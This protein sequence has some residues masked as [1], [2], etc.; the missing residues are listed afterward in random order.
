MKQERMKP[1]KLKAKQ[2]AQTTT[3]QVNKFSAKVCF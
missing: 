3:T 2:I 1:T